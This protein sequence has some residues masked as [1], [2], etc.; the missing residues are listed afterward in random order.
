MSSASPLEALSRA[1][2]TWRFDVPPSHRRNLSGL[3]VTAAKRVFV[4]TLRPM[5]VETLRP[6]REFNLAAVNVLSQISLGAVSKADAGPFIRS[7]LDGC[8]D[9]ANWAVRSHRENAVGNA[10]VRTKA[11]YLS[12]M[13]PVLRQ[14][15][16]AQRQFNELAISNLVEL[17][18]GT[19]RPDAASIAEQARLGDLFAVPLASRALRA[20]RPLWNEVFRAQVAFN[21][22]LA[23]ALKFFASFHSAESVFLPTLTL[24][25]RANDPGELLLSV[26]AQAYPAAFE[27][28]VVGA[29]GKEL[30][31]ARR[32]YAW[33]RSATSLDEAVR[34]ARGDIVVF[35][36]AGC[37][38][39]PGF[40]DAHA[41]T[42]LANE[43]TDAVTC[44]AP[45]PE[46]LVD[47]LTPTSF[48]NFGTGVFSVKRSVLA[49]SG[50][51]GTGIDVGYRLYEL[52]ARVTYA[53]GAQSRRESRSPQVDPLPGF[54]ASHREVTWLS[55]A[56]R[57]RASKRLRI[58]TYRWHCAH[59]YELF[60][61]PHDFTLMIGEPLMSK[62]WD[63]TVRP[64]RP[65]ARFVPREQLNLG[66]FDL[67]ILP[68]DESSLN[69]A[70]ANGVVPPDWGLQFRQLRHSLQIPII[71]LC[72]GTV[73]FHGQFDSK[74]ERPNLV[75]EF[76]EPERRKIVEHIGE[77]PVV[78]NSHQAAAEWGFRDSRVIWHGFDPAEYPLSTR[79][80]GALTVCPG[81]S[82]RPHYCGYYLWEKVARMKGVECAI[83]GDDVRGAVRVPEPPRTSTAGD[84][85]AHHRFRNY[86]D[87]IREY[88]VFFNPTLLSP[89]PRSRAEAMLC[90]LAMVTTP[91]HDASLFM[92]DGV[93]GFVSG[94][95][96]ELAEKLVW[97]G[98]N[99]DA[100]RKLGDAARET[101]IR[102]FHIDR[103]LDQWRELIAKVVG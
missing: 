25:V 94:D 51:A 86:V 3:G 75:V 1:L 45:E 20:T 63:F 18:A 22:E 24:V 43:R 62:Q 58:L 99:P 40:L 98:K 36:D 101:A 28:F 4:R 14:L 37:V 103:Y 10:I 72:H 30:E 53:A 73:P 42:Y 89:M 55:R 12:A 79:R 80:K 59:Q 74:H 91:N 66:E 68:F 23:A 102:E 2:E 47:P 97:L 21:Q 93:N 88:S 17:A 50:V 85:Y 57:V 48:V 6:Q 31:R 67:A 9:P 26:A 77:L 56:G 49:K 95:P 27:V 81:I 29:G 54:L 69:P 15:L 34:A 60:K 7:Q 8:S 64:L 52:G 33:L 65:N 96:G 35:V 11:S 92:R 46:T 38:L 83:V 32:R 70:L 13:E 78:C 41:R 82:R 16:D 84:D 90:G 61:L 5:H 76:N 44:P 87:F 100:A 19:L 71:A 39:S